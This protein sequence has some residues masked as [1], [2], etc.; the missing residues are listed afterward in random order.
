MPSSALLPPVVGY[1]KPHEIEIR[2]KHQQS[3]SGLFAS[4]PTESQ[5]LMVAMKAVAAFSDLTW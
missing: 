3:W 1:M 2:L 4:S 5:R